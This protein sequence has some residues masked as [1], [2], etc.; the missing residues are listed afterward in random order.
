M[1]DWKSFVTDLEDQASLPSR[2]GPMREILNAS[3]TIDPREPICRGRGMSPFYAVGELIWY[4][5]GTDDG[6]MI[7]FYAPSYERFL[8]AKGRADG[9]YGPRIAASFESVV[10]EIRSGNSRR[11]VLP[12]FWH[13]DTQRLANGCL[14]IP[15][16]LSI[17]FHPRGDILH[18]IVTMRSND[19][20]LGFPYDVFCFSAIHR[21]I[22]TEVGKG[23]GRYYHNSG[24]LHL[25]DRDLKK[26]NKKRTDPPS[27]GAVCESHLADL[28]TLL[29]LEEMLRKRELNQP[30]RALELIDGAFARGSLFHDMASTIAIY[31]IGVDECYS[32]FT[33]ISDWINHALTV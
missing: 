12:I 4:L 16:T 7:K 23:V 8:N 24:S 18:M 22:A 2:N 13:L 3:V 17:Q 25:Y 11:A 33:G 15:C 5:K 6:E 26:I 31:A 32:A 21:L 9:A 10:N 27:I 30:Y 19:V 1:I 14:D 28:G 29:S 20:F